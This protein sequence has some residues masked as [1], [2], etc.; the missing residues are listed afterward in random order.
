MKILL[1]NNF[2]QKRGGA[3]VSLMNT[4]RL[5]KENG[6]TVKI[7]YFS[8]NQKKINLFKAMNLIYSVKSKSEMRKVLETYNPDLVH[9]NNIYHHL[10]PSIID[11]IKKKDIPIVITL[12][13]YKLVCANY[14]LWRNDKICEDCRNRKFVNIIKNKCN[15]KG[16]Y[17]ESLLLWIEMTMHH[18]VL[19]IYDKIDYFVSPSKFLIEKFKDMGFKQ[20][21]NFIPNFVFLDDYK[22]IFTSDNKTIVYFGRLVPEKGLISLIDAVKDLPISLKIIGEGPQKNILLQKIHQEKIT[23]VYFK[24]WKNAES[25]NK[26][27]TN[28]MFTVLP[29]LWY[30]NNPRS[31]IESFSMGKTVVASDIGGIPEIV[32]NKKNGL[33]FKP[34][35]VNDLSRKILFLAKN[36]PLQVKMGREARITAEKK[37]SEKIHYQSLIKIYQM[38][39]SKKI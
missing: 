37:Y 9:L 28:S 33:L 30:E 27:I 19:H 24:T 8:G 29:S 11:V 4:Y 14:K 17:L 36:I 12:R 16:S 3:E 6:H 13:D 39:I 7:F 18:K 25:L 5:L 32:K 23:N 21:I 38:A 34:D 10:S 1:V 35:D 31:I 22:P 20:D 26:E 2:Y 15:L